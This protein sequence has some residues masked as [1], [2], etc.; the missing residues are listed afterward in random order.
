MHNAPAG[1]EL[2]LL[3]SR[4][5]INVLAQLMPSKKEVPWPEDLGVLTRALARGHCVSSETNDLAV[6]L[7]TRILP[8]NCTHSTGEGTDIKHNYFNR[9]SYVTTTMTVVCCDDGVDG[10]LSASAGQKSMYV[11]VSIREE[12]ERVNRFDKSV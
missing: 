4:N 6:P 10:S 7:F 1:A 9:R 12:I 8:A 5:F 3:S 2:I 11:V